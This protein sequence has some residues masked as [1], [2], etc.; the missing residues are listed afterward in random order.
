MKKAVCFT[1]MILMLIGTSMPSWAISR[2][3][4]I[5][6]TYSYNDLSIKEN[7]DGTCSITIEFKNN[8]RK[9]HKYVFITIYAYDNFNELLWEKLFKINTIQAGGTVKM[10]D[11][12]FRCKEDNPYKLEFEV[13]E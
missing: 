9:T 5:S 11:K 2:W 6:S 10:T 4:K 13:T 3:G 7:R 1:T 12:I 8:D